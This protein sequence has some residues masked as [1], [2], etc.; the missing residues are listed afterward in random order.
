MF[1]M[2]YVECICSFHHYW[3]L[4][5]Y[6]TNKQLTELAYGD[7]K[8][9]PWRLIRLAAENLCGIPQSV[10]GLCFLRA[11]TQLKAIP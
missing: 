11:P 8:Q 4:C 9:L 7:T 1:V 3:L 5:G 2:K 10:C 6:M